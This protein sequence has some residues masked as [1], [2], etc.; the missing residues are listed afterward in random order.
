MSNFSSLGDGELNYHFHIANTHYGVTQGKSKDVCESSHHMVQ[1]S[2]QEKSD[3]LE[4]TISA[5]NSALQ[6]TL[7]KIGCVGN[8]PQINSLVGDINRSV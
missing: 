8:P 2:Q 6:E 5:F 7:G 1:K 4:A 3:A